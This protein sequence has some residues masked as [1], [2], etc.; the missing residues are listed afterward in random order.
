M[1]ASDG[2]YVY[3][4]SI[5]S[6]KLS[7]VRKPVDPEWAYTIV[8]NEEVYDAGSSQD[9]EL[10]ETT[11]LEIVMLILQM[12]GVSINMLQVTQYAQAMEAQG[13]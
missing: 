4:A 7:Y 10:L 3:P 2:I 9:F 12:M 13:K 6:I 8:N 5:T 1:L 11:H